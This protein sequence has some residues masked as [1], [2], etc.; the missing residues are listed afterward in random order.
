M[1][2][3]ADTNVLFTFFWKD[4]VI[5]GM[6]RQDIQLAA[7]AY[8]LEEIEK[9]RKEILKKARIG[10]SGFEGAKKELKQAVAFV[11]RKRYETRFGEAA[12][13]AASLNKEDRGQMLEDVDFL[14]L[15][16][17]LGCALWSND[18]LL[19]SQGKVIVLSTAEVIELADFVG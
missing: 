4:S 1:R 13:C 14:A 16:M 2:L 9:H 15:A 5:R 18:K 12:S 7:P 6:L 3:V 17:E 10:P 19:K 8:A 11:E